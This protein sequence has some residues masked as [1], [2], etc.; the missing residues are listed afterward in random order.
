MELFAPQTQPPERAQYTALSLRAAQ[1]RRHKRKRPD[2][3]DQHD[4]GGPRET[5]DDDEHEQ[6]AD[7]AP[8]RTRT[9]GAR[10]QQ[11]L[12]ALEPPLFTL[13]PAGKRRQVQHQSLD[14]LTALLHRCLLEG[15]YARAGRAWGLILRTHVDGRPID[16]RNH[17][18]WGIGAELL[19][20]RQT[21]HNATEEPEGVSPYSEEGFELA[22]EYYERLVVQHPP[23]KAH[24]NALSAVTFYPAMFSLW[25]YDVC[26][27]SKRA[28]VRYMDRQPVEDKAD[29]VPDS[30]DV[31][32][33]ELKHAQE[34]A[35]RL[36][37]LM[38]SPPF[39]RHADMLQIRGMVGLW[40]AD[41]MLKEKPKQSN[42]DWGRDTGVEES[43]PEE[44][45]IARVDRLSTA[46]GEL[47]TALDYLERAQAHGRHVSRTINK[48][49]AQ[50]EALSKTIA[51]IG[52]R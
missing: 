12:A 27:R 50:L 28:R 38:T 45:E 5:L 7:E 44:S 51:N 46:R 49:V 10:L 47:R 23:L 41:L 13:A 16:P 4:A 20:H 36:N 1:Y 9:S 17:D 6:F 35:A 3:Q 34:I 19:L 26:E 39:D 31:D 2:E 15:D 22:R 33:E 14:V 11:R 43:A 42:D 48:T 24:P 29:M 8:A 37:Q 25:I 18:R 21:T 40:I 52:Q 30:A 32:V